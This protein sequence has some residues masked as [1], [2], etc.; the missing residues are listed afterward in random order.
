MILNKEKLLY[1]QWLDCTIEENEMWSILIRCI[2]ISNREDRK[3]KPDSFGEISTE[4][5]RRQ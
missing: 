1:L 5:M 4:M 2:Q 3:L